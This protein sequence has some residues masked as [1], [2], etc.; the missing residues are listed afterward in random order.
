MVLLEAAVCTARPL[1]SQI[2][3]RQR[4]PLIN[5]QAINKRCPKPVTNWL[6]IS[7]TLSSGRDLRKFSSSLLVNYNRNVVPQTGRNMDIKS[8]FAVLRSLEQHSQKT[9]SFL[10]ALSGD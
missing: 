8:A 1:I 9:R 3:V 2:P 4:K 6:N 10:L 5:R 7:F